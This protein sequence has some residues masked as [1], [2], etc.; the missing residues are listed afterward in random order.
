M[1]LKI[2]QL[3]AALQKVQ[4][5]IGDADVVFKDAEADA[6]TVLSAI[7]LQL[8][9]DG[10]PT[11]SGVSLVHAKASEADKSDDTPALT[12]DTPPA[13]VAGTT[14]AQP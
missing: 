12:A 1:G 3:A 14:P 10:N 8:G 4:A 6:Q 2:S 13:E 5:A 7:E 9:P 11:T